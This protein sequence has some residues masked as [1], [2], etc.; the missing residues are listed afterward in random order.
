MSNSKIEIKLNDGFSLVVEAST[1]P[2]YPAEIY[3][4]VDKD[5][6]IHQDLCVVHT[7]GDIASLNAENGFDVFLYENP[8]SDDWTKSFKIDLYKEDKS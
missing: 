7:S 1:D 4:G 5:G 6:R 3:V 2:C 8:N